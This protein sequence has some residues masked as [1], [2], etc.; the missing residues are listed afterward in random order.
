MQAEVKRLTEEHH[1][2]NKEKMHFQ[3]LVTQLQQKVAF[4]NQELD[5]SKKRVEK[6]QQDCQEHLDTSK[7]W[8]AQVS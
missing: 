8:R 3:S 4:V 1:E 7:A 2:I 6:K 5:K